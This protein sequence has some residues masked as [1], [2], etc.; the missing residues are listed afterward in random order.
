MSWQL[1]L[2]DVRDCPEG[3]TLARNIEEAKKLIENNGLPSYMS[4]DHDLGEE[5][6][7]QFAERLVD[8]DLDGKLDLL[9]TSFVS[10]SANPV[11]REKIEALLSL[12]CK[13]KQVEQ[14]NGPKV[15]Q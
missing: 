7:Y 12:Y 10:H 6:G 3:F 5:T 4:L 11:G 9:Q 2:D 1:Y 13:I 15:D 8:Q 14:S